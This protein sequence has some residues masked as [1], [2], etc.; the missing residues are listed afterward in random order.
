MAHVY[1]DDELG[2]FYVVDKRGRKI[3]E[4]KVKKSK[5]SSAPPGSDRVAD[6]AAFYDANA[7][8]EVSPF[9]FEFE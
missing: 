2:C 1:R 3:R 8:C 9:K 7:S 4:R 5:R 6:L